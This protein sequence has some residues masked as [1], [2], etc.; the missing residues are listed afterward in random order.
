MITE[1]NL[2]EKI[3][4]TEI[5]V[6]I[7]S[8]NESDSIGFVAEQVDEGLR[9]YFPEK[10]SIIINI[11]NSPDDKT[12]KAF[13]EAKIKGNKLTIS[14]SELRMGKGGNI[15]VLLEIARMLRAKA[16]IMVDSDLKSITPEWIKKL[17]EPIL[18]GY[19]FAAPLYSRNHLDG[20]ITNNIVYPIIYGLAGMDVRQPIGGEFSFSDK[21][22]NYWLEKNWEETTYYYG[23][24][25][26]M[27]INTIVGNFKICQVG[28]GA[29]IHKPSA[30]KLNEMFTQ[31]VN[32]LAGIIT[33]AN[34]ENNELR[35]VKTFHEKLEE[36][37]E[38]QL[39]EET[40][41]NNIKKHWEESSLIAKEFLPENRYEEIKELFKNN[42]YYIND[43]L[44]AEIVYS[45]LATFKKTKGEEKKKLVEGLKP[46]YFARVL[47]YMRETK[48]MTEEQA[49]SLIKHQA[50]VFREK[51]NLYFE[52][53]RKE[54]KEVM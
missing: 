42:N 37:Q 43:S 29:K 1:N 30:P 8:Y 40:I 5:I 39:N 36:P 53:I 48:N 27:S 14:T 10:E 51:R 12:I 9:K 32:T 16:I 7:P 44:W 26:F 11:D 41:I 3:R 47:S 15:R 4:A 2:L 34:L 49:E 24:D 22:V 20:T 54:I 33:T 17:A 28:L 38:L 6:G 18:S 25:N 35:E 50:R 19:D 46:L 52:A 21:L 45:F 23:I 31:V 13:K